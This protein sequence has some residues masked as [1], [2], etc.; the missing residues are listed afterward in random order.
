MAEFKVN[1]EFIVADEQSLRSLFHATHPLAAQKCLP[2]LDKHAQDFIRR[3]PF[4]CA[5]G[6][7]RGRPT[8]F[9]TAAANPSA[10]MT[11]RPS[12]SYAA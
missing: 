1:P 5:T 4:I 9:D 2:A 3:S 12:T 11:T 10:R 6:L 7:S 8:A